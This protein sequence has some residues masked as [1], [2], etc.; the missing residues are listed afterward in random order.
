M[1]D[2]LVYVAVPARSEHSAGHHLHCLL[3][4]DYLHLPTL[5]GHAR[6]TGFG[7]SVD[8]REIG[9]DPRDKLRVTSYVLGQTESVFGS[10]GHVGNAPRPKGKRAYL[11]PHDATLVRVAPEVLSAIDR[12]Q[13]AHLSDD[14]LAQTCPLFSRRNRHPNVAS[15]RSSERKV[16]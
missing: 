10:K 13:S 9:D 16:A 3:W 12:A 2:H 4:K 8:I 1:P 11:R 15:Y 5:I 6:D 7:T 14:E